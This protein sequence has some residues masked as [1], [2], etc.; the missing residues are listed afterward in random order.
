MRGGDCNTFDR[1]ESLAGA[2][3]SRENNTGA[4]RRRATRAVASMAVDATECAEVLAML[5]LEAGEGR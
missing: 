1:Y 4:D 2:G 3:R 5:G